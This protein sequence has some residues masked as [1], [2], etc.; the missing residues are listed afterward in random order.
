ML[1]RIHD[2]I[3]GEDKTVEG[4]NVGIN[5]GTVAGQTILHCHVHLILR[6]SGD[7]RDP[8]GGVR[9]TLPGKARYPDS[10]ARTL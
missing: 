10:S 9:A 6:R 4:F 7:V 8:W 3:V 5:V 1:R 2:D